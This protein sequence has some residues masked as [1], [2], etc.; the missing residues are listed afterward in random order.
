MLKT[1]STAVAPPPSVHVDCAHPTPDTWMDWANLVRSE[2]VE[3]PGLSL[4]GRQVERLWT[5]DPTWA[6]AIL[7]HL[8]N[9]GFLSCTPKGTYV[10]A[11]TAGH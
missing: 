10:R 11:D 7:A 8:V 9:A 6:S 5:L 4:S 1:L 2:Y 3:M